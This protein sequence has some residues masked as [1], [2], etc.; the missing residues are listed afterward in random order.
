MITIFVYCKQIWEFV[1]IWFSIFYQFQLVVFWKTLVAHY[2][3]N[4]PLAN[5]IKAT[6]TFEINRGFW[7]VKC[8]A[9]KNR[10]SRLYFFYYFSFSEKESGKWVQ[11]KWLFLFLYGKVKGRPFWLIILRLFFAICARFTQ[12]GKLNYFLFDS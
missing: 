5:C 12:C 10:L 9:F 11:K 4:I 6:T 2:S 8:F 1:N 7:K 3:T